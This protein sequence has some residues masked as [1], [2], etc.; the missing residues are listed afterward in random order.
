[1]VFESPPDPA[2]PPAAWEKHPAEPDAAYLL[3]QAYLENPSPNVAVFARGV[4]CSGTGTAKIQALAARWRWHARRRA[5]AEHLAQASAESA[6]HAARLQGERMAQLAGDVLDVAQ[7]A[8][9]ALD[10]RGAVETMTPREV[11]DYAAKGIEIARL[12]RGEVTARTGLDLSGLSQD[13]RDT[14]RGLLE[15]AQGPA[16]APA[17]N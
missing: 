5:L 7:R 9:T 14:V 15:R 12:L 16:P 1:M 8:L 4:N 3:F 17:E 13:E 11:L 6:E 10:M 2:P